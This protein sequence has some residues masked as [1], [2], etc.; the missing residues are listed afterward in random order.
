MKPKRYLPFSIII[1]LMLVNLSPVSVQAQTP[2]ALYDQPLAPE[3]RTLPA[4][5][6][7]GDWAQIRALL[8]AQHAYLKASNSGAVDFFDKVAIS[9]DTVVVG[10]CSEDSSA[11]GVNGNQKDNAAPGSGAAYVFVRASGFWSQQ[12]YLKASN[13]ERGDGFGC[14]VAIS[15]DTVVV[16]ARGEDSSATGVNG[17]Q[18]DNAARA[19][20]AAYVFV[21]AG[22]SWSQQAYLKASNTEAQD[23][24]GFTLAISGDTLVVGTPYEDSVATGVNGNQNDNAAPDSGAAYI[25]VRAGG[26]WSQQAYLKASNSEAGDKFGYSVAPSGDTLV[27]GARD[28]DSGATGVNGDQNDNAAPYSGA[29]YVFVRAGGDWSQQAYLKASNTEA[30]EEFGYALALSSDTVVVGARGEDSGATGVN[31]DQN[32][33]SAFRSGAAYVFVR[34]GGAWSQQAY[35]KASNTETYD[36]FGSSVAVSGDTVVVGAPY[37][38]SN[39]TGV[40]GDQHDNSAPESGAAYVFVRAGGAWSQQAY[41]KASNTEADDYFS[42][43]VAVSGNT[44][45]VGAGLEDSSATGVNGNQDDNAAPDS[46]AAYVYTSKSSLSLRS[47]AAQDGWMLESGEGTTK[48]GRRNNNATILSLGDD[49]QKKQYRSILSF[50]TKDLPDNAIIA[51]VT[52]KVQRQG[53]LGDGEPVNIFK[54][55]MIDIRKGFFGS[56]AGLQASDFQSNADK[57]YGPFKPALS[58]GWYSI[59]LTPAKAYINKLAANGGVTQVRLRF[60]LDDN[61]NKEANV[62]SLYSGDAPQ[63]SRPQLII[64]YYVP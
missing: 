6:S 56:A 21:R 39:A 28:E 61:N 33:N 20:G 34:A 16:G 32:D 38:A 52:L 22:R 26:A 55:V 10:A 9:G 30:N 45:V 63:A 19:S 8:P 37:E 12:A 14:P 41:L 1:I 5:L 59:N 31:G 29:A 51:R 53:V 57:S 43:S 24:F 47:Q 54:G 48:G 46:G 42:D 13:T 3:N 25:F 7:A 60:K 64:E 15:G 27:V 50:T 11:S 4:G 35:L 2:P 62:L 18:H 58:G 23:E 49:A 40:N 36:E 17:N 44:V